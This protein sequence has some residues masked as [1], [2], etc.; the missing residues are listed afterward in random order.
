MV[1]AAETALA[2]A[3]KY[4]DPAPFHAQVEGLELGFYPAG[5]DRLSALLE[6]IEAARSSLKLAFYIFT[7]D[8]V[9]TMVRDALVGAA[10]R[11]VSVVVIVDGFGATADAAF[12]APLTDAGGDFRIFQPNWSRRYLIRNH[13]K[14]V[15]AD[16][17]TA[18]LGGFNIAQDYF[19]PPASDGWNDLAVTVKGDAA[20]RI[21]Q[22]FSELE[23]WTSAKRLRFRAIRKSVREW[24]SGSG[25]VRVLIGGPTKGLSSWARMI[26]RDLM[27]G[28]KLDIMMAYFAPSRRLRRR[29]RQIALKG[30]TNLVMAGKTDNGATMGAARLLYRR[31]LK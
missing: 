17:E 30:E 26:S 20:G 5:S 3:A 15:I 11:G 12:F 27:Y 9:G 19:D 28:K 8:R 7:P 21:S 2:E 10:K 4:R 22:W 24:D 16:D 1:Q 29:M 18:I 13:Q 23:Q 6:V 14:I 25:P 31:F